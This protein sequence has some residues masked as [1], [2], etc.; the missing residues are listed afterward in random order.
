MQYRRAWVPGGTFFFT[1][2]LADRRAD[3]LV[4]HVDALRAA[5]AVVRRRH[6]FEIV[7][8]A[9]MPEHLHAV[10]QLPPGD[11]DYAGRW[12]LIKAGFSRQLPASERIGASRRTKGERGIW[13]R[14]YWE[15]QIRDETDLA[16]HIDYIHFNPVKHGH[17]RNA[18]DWPHSSLHRYIRQGR[19][20]ANW[21]SPEHAL[22]A[23]PNTAYWRALE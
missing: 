11:A 4:R 7:A 18:V 2:N 14:R 23:P 13:Q 1:V 22:P 16:N 8:I 5:F 19:L 17:V 15:H 10:W 9:V 20:P 6:P 21:G 3:T 12:A